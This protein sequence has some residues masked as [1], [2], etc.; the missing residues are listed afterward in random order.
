[1]RMTRRPD[2]Q[3]SAGAVRHVAH[4]AA[5]V[6]AIQNT[7]R[8][9][10]KVGAGVVPAATDEQSGGQVH[11]VGEGSTRAGS[12]VDPSL[13]TDLAVLP[14]AH[15]RVQGGCQGIAIGNAELLGGDR[16]ALRKGQGGQYPDRGFHQAA[17]LG[18]A[19]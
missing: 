3:S 12:G 6:L 9:V 16:G 2:D 17:P 10:G 19:D 11:V 15:G 5:R 14:V 13:Q 7:E 4:R 18:V 8:V 1:M